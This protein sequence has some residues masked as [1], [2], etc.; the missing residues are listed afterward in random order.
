M[1]KTR[2]E[3]LKSL[4]KDPLLILGMQVAVHVLA[5]VEASSQDL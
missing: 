5:W 3:L 4:L 1:L 2:C